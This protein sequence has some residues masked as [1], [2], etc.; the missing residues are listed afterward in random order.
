MHVDDEQNVDQI[1]RSSK[2]ERSKDKGKGTMVT[3]NLFKNLTSSLLMAS[4]YYRTPSRE[5]GSRQQKQ[6]KTL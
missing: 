3:Y 6:Q 2:E 1:M 5:R 4:I